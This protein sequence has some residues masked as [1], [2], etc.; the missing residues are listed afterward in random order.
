MSYSGLES[1]VNSGQPIELYEFRRGSEYYRYTTHSEVVTYLSNDYEPSSISRDRVKQTADSFKNDLK[2][3]LPRSDIF[4]LSFITYAPEEVATLTV[5]RGHVNDGEYIAYWKGRVLGGE[6]SGN[7]ITLTLESAFTSL[8]RAGLRARFEFTC[9][10]SLYSA[11]CGVNINSFDASGNIDAISTNGLTVTLSEASAQADGYYTGGFMMIGGV[12]R[13]ITS[14]IGANLELSAAFQNITVG[15][16]A[17]IYA[18][19]DHTRA[20]CNSKFSNIINF[21][22]FPFIPSKNPFDAGIF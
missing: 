22:G 1:S 6:I 14:H 13:F 11:G 18:G 4:A 21:G 7:E 20:T 16:L 15:T 2:I 17:V 12:R 5:Y 10:H 3:I 19:C 8:R 9:R